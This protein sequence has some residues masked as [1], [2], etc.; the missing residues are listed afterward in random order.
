MAHK[1]VPL[2]TLCPPAFKTQSLDEHT[3]HTPTHP[4]APSHKISSHTRN[5][6]CF[7]LPSRLCTHFSSVSFLFPFWSLGRSISNVITCVMPAPATNSGAGPSANGGPLLLPP[8]FVSL[9]PQ[10]SL[11]FLGLPML[12]SKWLI[13]R[14]ASSSS[15]CH[16]LDSLHLSQ[17]S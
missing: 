3:G 13:S 5:T 14:E 4:A 11:H 10:L 12:S 16:I 9:L 15:L 6:S 8:S 17:S 2:A 7:L 1:S